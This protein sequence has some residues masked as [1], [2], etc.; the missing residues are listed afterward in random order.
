MEAVECGAASLRIV[1]GHFGC[2]VPLEELRVACGVSRDG[3]KASNI[4]RAAREYGMQAKGFRKNPESIRKLRMPLIIHWNFNHFLVLEGFKKD[5]AYLSDPA[6]GRYAVTMEEFD[7]AF[8]GVALAIVPG[9]G[10]QKTKESRSIIASLMPRIQRSR[11]ALSFIF[12]ASLGLVIPGLVIPTFN[13]VFIDQYLV[14]RMSDW[15]LPLLLVMGM[16]M[17]MNAALTWLQQRYLLR[18]QTKLA[19]SMSSGFLQHILR[20]PVEFFNQRSAGEIG[21]RVAIN[22][23]VASM[24]AGEVATTLLS[25][26]TMIFYLGLMLLYDVLLTVISV[27]MAALNVAALLLVARKRVDGNRRLLQD[28][29]KLLGV[30]MNGLRMIET[31]KASAAEGAY[32]TKW[33][34]QF[35]KVIN[36]QQELGSYT[37]ALNT[38]PSLLQSVA[39][40]AVLSLGSL[41]VMDGELTIGML[42]AFQFLMAGFL[43]PVN[44]LVG[45][46]GMLQEAEGDM[47][48][49]DDVLR[50]RQAPYLGNGTPSTHPVS[51]RAKLRGSLEVRDLTFGYS[52]LAPPLFNEYSMKVAPGNW[53]ALVGTSGCGK[54][55]LAR[56]VGG[57]YEPWQG[58]I[59]FDGLDRSDLS[60]A[61]V[62]NS[63]AVVDQDILLYND[64]ILANLSLWDRSIPREQIV[65]AAHDACAHDFIMMRPGEYDG[66]LNEGGND[67]SGGQRQRLEIARALASNPSFLILD[68]AT[69]AL[70]PTTERVVME[71]IRRRGCSC[72]IVAHRLSTIRDCDEIITLDRGT[73][74][75]RGTHDQLMAA[76]GV[77]ASLIEAT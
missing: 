77:Y 73:V 41:R 52:R 31:I 46:A 72:L 21:S 7:Q 19:I 3:T 39:I 6:H 23:R 45:V 58:Q 67:L 44:N 11:A 69:S 22:D 20:L 10:F 14:R 76:G 36:A 56:L 66:T 71:N 24:I 54:S 27:V 57:L 4:V 28:H 48:R 15:V 8:T 50:H 63:V 2:W 32:F 37:R 75:E 18:L 12:L 70:D 68:E 25:V 38:V 35:V 62:C 59:L 33:A 42:I 1:L 51:K 47:N 65:K 60:R 74:V 29:G 13:T 61:I 43:A 49:L 16:I 30:T 26:V 17:L 53:V 40:L 64:S 5:R 34:G 9:E 55:T